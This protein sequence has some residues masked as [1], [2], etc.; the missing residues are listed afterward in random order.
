ML[1][2]RYECSAWRPVEDVDRTASA[3]RLEDRSWTLEALKYDPL[4]STRN[5]EMVKTSLHAVILHP[6]RAR[7]S[8]NFLLRE[9]HE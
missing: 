6:G 9:I 8:A 1:C 2:T 4:S 3:A 7:Q 5:R